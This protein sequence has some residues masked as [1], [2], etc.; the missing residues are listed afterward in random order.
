MQI[1]VP[2]IFQIIGV[3]VRLLAFMS[4]IVLT[5]MALVY[6]VSGTSY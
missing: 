2:L 5:C 4:M 1:C 3:L 6:A